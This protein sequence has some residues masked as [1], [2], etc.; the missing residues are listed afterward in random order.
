MK[1]I[2]VTNNTNTNVNIVRG[3]NNLQSGPEKTAQSLMC[4]HFNHL[5]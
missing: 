4:R 3:S 5:Q 2:F 1:I